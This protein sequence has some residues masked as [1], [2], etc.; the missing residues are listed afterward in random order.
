MDAIL[1]FNRNGLSEKINNLNI[2]DECY[3]ANDL[4]EILSNAKERDKKLINGYSET[5]VI[6]KKVERNKLIRSVRYFTKSGVARYLHE[7]KLFNYKNACAHF[8]VIPIDLDIVEYKKQ[9]ARYETVDGRY[10]VAPVLKWLYG[11]RKS[12]K[13]L[14]EIATK[15]EIL[16]FVSKADT[17]A[18]PVKLEILS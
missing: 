17:N 11:K 1:E 2:V 15:E 3:P 7:G 10:K 18:D 6:I 5:E 9:L 4:I 12:C 8:G 16:E 14:G 13:A